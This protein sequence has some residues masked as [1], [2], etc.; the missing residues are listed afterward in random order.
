MSQH[1]A[2]ARRA[3][4]RDRPLAR[5]TVG[6]ALIAAVAAPVAQGY[7]GYGAA[8]PGGAGGTNV[9]PEHCWFDAEARSLSDAAVET[10][11]ATMVDHCHDAANDPA[12]ECDVDL[13]ES[14]SGGTGAG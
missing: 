4:K 7:E 10:L 13:T 14:R 6:L 1:T 11:V 12:C 8:T 5:A 3:R 9:V 2:H